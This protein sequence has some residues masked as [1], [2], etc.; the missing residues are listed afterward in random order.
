MQRVTH[1]QCATSLLTPPPHPKFTHFFC[2]SSTKADFVVS[3]KEDKSSCLLCVA[4]PSSSE[5]REESYNV[6]YYSL[7]HLS[8]AKMCMV[9]S[10]TNS[11]HQ[12]YYFQMCRQYEMPS[13][14]AAIK[15]LSGRQDSNCY[16][17]DLESALT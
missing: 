2:K 1:M 8:S 17:E 6:F 9:C 11:S 12:G 10:I 5:I 15:K 16:G 13:L 4:S 14:H 3:E 7:S